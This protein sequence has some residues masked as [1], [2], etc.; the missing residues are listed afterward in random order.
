MAGYF[1][2]ISNEFEEIDNTKL[3]LTYH[4]DPLQLSQQAVLDRHVEMNKPK[5]SVSIDPLTRFVNQ[6]ADLFTPILTKVI[7]TILRGSP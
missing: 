2:T 7:N 5:S 4:R 3:P 1:A 6:H